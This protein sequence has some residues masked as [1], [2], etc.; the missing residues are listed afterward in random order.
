MSSFSVAQGVRARERVFDF[1]TDFIRTKGPCAAGFRWYLRHHDG[2]AAYQDVLDALVAA[3]RVSDACWLLDQIGPT[4]TLLQVD[5]LCADAVVFAGTIEA[6]RG[7]DVG[8]LLRAGRSIRSGASLFA[9]EAV[10]AGDDLRAGGFIRCGGRVEVK[11][12]A[13]AEAG[14]D[15]GGS[16]QCGGQF[17]AGSRVSVSGPARVV[18]DATVRDDLVVEGDLH[19][20]KALRVAGEISVTGALSAGQGIEC[21]QSITAGRHLDAGLGIRA[22]D[23][24]RAG[25][26]IR[27]GE[28]IHAQGR[29]E[30]GEGYGIYA[31]VAVPLDCWDISATVSAAERPSALLSGFWTGRADACA[32]SEAAP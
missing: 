28:S 27:A 6:R 16:L 29:L 11:G 5:V 10:V 20:G 2:G 7:I 30:P 4:T 1:T 17:R 22:G 21:G 19:C 8:T 31:G 32:S 26:A 23:S 13:L 25:G 18:E 12:N 9:G 15:A 24:I 3:G 14:L